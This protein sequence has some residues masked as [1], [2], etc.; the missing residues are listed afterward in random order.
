MQDALRTP[1]LWLLPTTW[2]LGHLAVGLVM[3]GSFGSTLRYAVAMTLPAYAF[4]IPVAAAF[5]DPYALWD[6]RGRPWRSAAVA[7]LGTVALAIVLAVFLRRT[8]FATA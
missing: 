8:M 1:L 4:G 3:G 6:A 7:A 2:V 5:T